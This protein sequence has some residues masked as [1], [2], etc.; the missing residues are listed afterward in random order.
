MSSTAKITPSSKIHE[1]YIVGKV[2]GFGGMGTVFLVTPKDDKSKRYAAKYMQNVF[3]ETAYSRFKEEAKL[4]KKLNS[5]YLPKFIEYYGDSMEQFYIM[6]YIEGTVLYN[7]IRAEGSLS[8]KRAKGYITK[9]A[10]GIG[11]LHANGIIHRDIKTQNIIVDNTHNIKIIDLGISL[12]DDSQRLTR[13]NA[14]I[15]SPY[16]AAPEYSIKGAEITKAVDIYALGIV[17]F[18]MLTGQYP[19]KAEREQDTIM[20]HYKSSF[21]S[22][23][24][25]KQIPQAMCNVVI[26]ATAKNPGDRYKNVYEF[27]KDTKTC[28]DASRRFE[29]PLNKKTLKPKKKL[30]ERLNSN[31][32]LIGAII[33]IILIIGAIALTLYFK[34]LL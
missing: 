5:Q 25:F 27:I 20:M 23:N 12:T 15:C 24:Q 28:L 2:V 33:F 18:E 4:L 22:P 3:D 16:Y 30:S 29:Q 11:E 13:A 7:L 14:V 6:E 8:V 1:K 10:E 31:G 34:G 21:P 19:Y 17:L 26:K 9:I 32:F